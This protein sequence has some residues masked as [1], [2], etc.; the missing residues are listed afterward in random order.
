MIRVDSMETN[1][2]QLSLRFAFSCF[3]VF[4]CCG[5]SLFVCVLCCCSSCVFLCF[6][7]SVVGVPG[8]LGVNFPGGVAG[9]GV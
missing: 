6:L 2:T 8:V 1:W 5:V 7:V 9:G 3:C 4:C